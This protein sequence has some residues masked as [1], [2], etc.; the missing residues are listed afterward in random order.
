MSRLINLR[1][2]FS[3]DKGPWERRLLIWGGVG[4]VW[5]IVAVIAAYYFDVATESRAFCGLLCHP[6]TPQY[7]TQEVSP[8]AD[9]ECGHCHV[10]PGLTPKVIAKIMG[11]QEL[12]MLVT[13]GYER[14][15]THPVARLKAA[16]V[17]CEQCHSPHQPYEDQIERFSRF[18]PD[19][20]NAETQTY[21][22]MKI[23]GG[24]D[25]GA[26][27][28]VDNPV[29]YISHDEEDYQDIPWAAVMGDDGKLVEYRSVSDP[30][31][32][33]DVANLQ[34]RELDCIGCHNRATHQFRNPED[35]VDEAM[36]S[37]EMDSSLPYLKRE[38]VALLS[39]S[40]LTQDAGLEAM[41]DLAKFYRTEYPDV[42]SEKEQVVL[43][44]VAS[45]QEIYG[46]TVFPEMNLT[47]DFY[48][49]NL[50]H[51]ESP[52]CF[53]CH[54]GDH[55]NAQGEA[56]PND[57]TL[58]HSVPTVVTGQGELDPFAARNAV[59]GG[60]QP[61]SHSKASFRWDHRILASDSCADCHGPI[62]Y[63]TDNSSFCANG[64]C[65][66]QEWADPPEAV[67]F[68]HPVQLVGQ[69]A[70]V[71][72]Y[73]CHQGE[74]EPVLDDCSTC[75]QPPS[76]A[77]F[78]PECS[79]C[80]TPQGFQESA[81]SWTVNVPSNP[82]GI[83]TLDCVQCHG[84]DGADPTPATH[85]GIPGE[86]CSECHKATAAAQVPSVPHK[87]AALSDCLSCHGESVS[88]P[89]SALHQGISSDLCLQC[90][91]SVPISGV[92]TIPHP[93]EGS[94]QCRAC[95]DEDRV[96]EVPDSHRGWT[97]EAC[98]ACHEPG[99]NS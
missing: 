12:Y 80:H 31:I 77:H 99:S 41:A 25:G 24:S 66:G 59:I 79:Q 6:N 58:C 96:A 62:E 46:Q 7:V 50:G 11:T 75:H 38:V 81:A 64:I 56:I 20:S 73:D 83:E 29:W 70:R 84:A 98:L 67:G 18:A 60:K 21:L 86:S 63:G 65:H 13:N 5:A 91:T 68:V 43:Q 76:E 49:D 14:P 51:I 33:E 19:E 94:P 90:H 82:H 47:W 57:C 40:Y 3:R 89:A 69:H 48:P 27:W 97:D 45:L 35:R 42:Y 10:G 23:G 30:P 88:L 4:V 85:Q 72:C 16:D 87:V 39:V 15:I 54:D 53:R 61:V 28:H 44:A 9:V 95:H 78:G 36:A 8:H 52:G 37:G 17:I 71:E 55:V 34:R 1:H 22:T 32:A 26:H 92:P 74:R 93:A 2:V